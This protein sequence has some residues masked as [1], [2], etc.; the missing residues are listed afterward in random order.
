MNV[1]YRG[2]DN[3]VSVSVSGYS[4]KDISATATNGVLSKTSDGYIMKPGRES[5]ATIGA[6][7]TNPDGTKVHDRHEIPGEERA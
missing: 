6:T 7:V 5:E 2:V 3:P 1:F 4:N